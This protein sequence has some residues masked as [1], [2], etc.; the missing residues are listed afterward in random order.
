[1]GTKKVTSSV[2]HDFGFTNISLRHEKLRLEK[3]VPTLSQFL[4]FK[5]Q[6]RKGINRIFPG[7]FKIKW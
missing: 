2:D 3:N 7:T 1:M 5:E 4:F 6:S